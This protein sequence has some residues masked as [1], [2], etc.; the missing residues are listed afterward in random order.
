MAAGLC[1]QR[2]SGEVCS[3][4]VRLPWSPSST[5]PAIIGLLMEGPERLRYE[6]QVQ[7][8]SWDAGCFSCYKTEAKGIYWFFDKPGTYTLKYFRWERSQRYF[9]LRLPPASSGRGTRYRGACCCL[10]LTNPILEM[11]LTPGDHYHFPDRPFTIIMSAIMSALMRLMM[12]ILPD[13][14]SMQSRQGTM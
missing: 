5:T 11:G 1:N 10:T 2:N 7:Y 9:Y 3:A 14:K 4:A 12:M 13:K 6:G 8:T